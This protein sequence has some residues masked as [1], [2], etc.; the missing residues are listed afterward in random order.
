MSDHLVRKPDSSLVSSTTDVAFDCGSGFDTKKRGP[1]GV[2]NRNALPPGRRILRRN[3]KRPHLHASGWSVPERKMKIGQPLRFPT[4]PEEYESLIGLVARATA[5][6]V[7]LD[8]NRVLRRA[9]IS[10]DRP[11]YL[12]RLDSA[13]LERLAPIIGCPVEEVL[14]RTMWTM[15]PHAKARRARLRANHLSVWDIETEHRRISPLAI[16]AGSRHRESWLLRILPYCSV[17]FELLRSD[18]SECSAPLRWKKSVGIDVCETCEQVVG[19]T[20]AALLDEEMRSDYALF[21]RL[22]CGRVEVRK[23]AFSELSP[24]VQDLDVET[25]IRMVIGIGACFHLKDRFVNRKSIHRLPPAQQAA[26]ISTG[27]GILREWPGALQLRSQEEAARLIA[28]GSDY[29]KLRARLQKLGHR[30]FVSQKQADLIRDALPDIFCNVQRSFKPLSDTLLRREAGKL[31]GLA[32]RHVDLVDAGLLAAEELGGGA[33]RRFRF[34]R[35]VVEALRR[36]IDGSTSMALFARQTYLPTYAIENLCDHGI[37]ERESDP[38]LFHLRHGSSI[39]RTSIESL[40]A[41]IFELERG[42]APSDAVPLGT[43][44]RRIGGRLKP[45]ADIV[46]ALRDRSLTCWIAPNATSETPWLRS[47]LIAPPQFAQFD[48]IAMT[49]PPGQSPRSLADCSLSDAKEILN[50]RGTPSVD[51]QDVFA[52][53]I[54]ACDQRGPR[55]A[56]PMAKVLEKAEQ[57]IGIGEICARANWNARQA[58]WALALFANDRTACGW[59]RAAIEKSGVLETQINWSVRAHRRD[60]RTLGS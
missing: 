18:C 33:N 19:P 55:K 15:L 9:G 21:A 42:T 57:E 10:M 2:R 17:S 59:N 27:T 41:A 60:P 28:G 20:D 11:G 35:S 37:L 36:R 7:L 29:R 52:K 54:A 47:I 40:R 24:A 5:D 44:T 46:V 16:L 53:E 51:L 13:T 22:I 50:L 3:V 58:K 14:S 43:A 38:A 45:W 34:D 26:I 30:W 32:V 8:L 56:V 49:E 23:K 31:L 48:N 4:I 6:H 25:L 12:T 1:R 39:T